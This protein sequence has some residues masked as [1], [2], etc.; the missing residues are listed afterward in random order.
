MGA[1]LVS[2]TSTTTRIHL[3]GRF[4]SMAMSSLPGRVKREALDLFP[5]SD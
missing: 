2:S 1:K 5:G 3:H 4:R